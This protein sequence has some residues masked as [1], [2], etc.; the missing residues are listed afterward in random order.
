M[1][2]VTYRALKKL[3]TSSTTGIIEHSVTGT[4]LTLTFA[5]GTKENIVFPTP[6][7]GVGI[8]SA[9][10][11]TDGELILTYTDGTSVNIGNVIGPQG[12]KGDK[13]DKGETPD[14]SNYATKTDI[15]NIFIGG[16]NLLLGTAIQDTEKGNVIYGATKTE[17]KFKGCFVYS[18]T[19]K[20][21]NIGF[22]LQRVIKD[23]DLKLGDIV[24][25]SI[26]VKCTQDGEKEFRLYSPEAT[27]NTSRSLSAY[28]INI[29]NKWI[30]LTKTFTID[31]IMMQL[32]ESNEIFTRFACT[33]DCTEGNKL[34]YAAPQLE[35]GNKATDY[36]PAPEDIQEQIDN[37]Q[38]AIL[39]LMNA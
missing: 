1:D 39:A 14:L 5:D 4:T 25:Y 28:N 31:E 6:K 19:R 36:R 38:D 18:T 32:V 2:I 33:T 24:T 22:N 8:S 21:N 20:Y 17:E 9:E 16:R 13:G 10:K 34:Y 15:S 7:N 12:P 23:N 11:N 26:Y 30:R 29:G 3:I 35:L 27:G 37:I